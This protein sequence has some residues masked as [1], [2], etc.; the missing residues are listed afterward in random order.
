M[1]QVR[2]LLQVVSKWPPFP[3]NPLAL[4]KLLRTGALPLFGDPKNLLLLELIVGVTVLQPYEQG[5]LTN[6][7]LYHAI[8][9]HLWPVH[10]EKLRDAH[11]GSEHRLPQNVGGK[12]IPPSILD[13]LARGDH[14]E[15]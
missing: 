12:E 10:I 13:K 9:L 4:G 14:Q 15:Q 8:T 11:P 5:V 3:R 7:K 2:G 6:L 1:V